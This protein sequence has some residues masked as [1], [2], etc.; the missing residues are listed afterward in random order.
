[1]HLHLESKRPPRSMKPG[2]LAEQPEE[3]GTLTVRQGARNGVIRCECVGGVGEGLRIW[4]RVG[5]VRWVLGTC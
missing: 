4:E 3:T 2:G 1:M 5:G